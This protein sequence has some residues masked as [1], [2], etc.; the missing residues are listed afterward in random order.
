MQQGARI[1]AAAAH[2]DEKRRQLRTAI[3]RFHALHSRTR[4]APR[5][6]RRRT[7]ASACAYTHTRGRA[8]QEGYFAVTQKPETGPH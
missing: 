3:D 5:S 7:R 4:P 8:S 2:P 1:A 6:V